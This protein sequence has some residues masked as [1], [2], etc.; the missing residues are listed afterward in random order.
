M[1]CSDECAIVEVRMLNNASRNFGESDIGCL[2]GI[3]EAE[4]EANGRL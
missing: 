1:S 2:L 3:E 4:D